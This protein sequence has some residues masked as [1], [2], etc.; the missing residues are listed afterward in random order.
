MN[1]QMQNQV[2]D[3]REERRQQREERRANRYENNWIAGV[4]LVALGILFLFRNM[5]FDVLDNWWALFILIPA[6][7]SLANAWRA[8]Q[9]D[10]RLSGAAQGSLFI[11]LILLGLAAAFLFDVNL[12][13]IGPL[14]IMAAGGYLLFKALRSQGT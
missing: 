8:Y 5:G 11:G 7:G 1:D 2:S 10:G 6:L 12:S 4:I 3:R 13:I 9:A 14:F